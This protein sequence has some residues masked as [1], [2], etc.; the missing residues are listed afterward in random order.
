M[1]YRSL[2]P[3]KVANL[4]N[5]DK[6]SCCHCQEKISLGTKTCPNCHGALATDSVWP[7]AIRVDHKETLKPTFNRNRNNHETLFDVLVGIC[8]GLVSY[9]ILSVAL[10]LTASVVSKKVLPPYPPSVGVVIWII[11]LTLPSLPMLLFS[12]RGRSSKPRFIVGLLTGM[13]LGLILEVLIVLFL[14]S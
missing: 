4:N 3:R 2:S 7:P 8:M 11:M 1:V 13:S 12:F 14:I 6:I 10:W 5:R 9:C